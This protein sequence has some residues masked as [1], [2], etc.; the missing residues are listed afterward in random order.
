MNTN[1]NSSIAA[2]T[3]AIAADNVLHVEFGYDE[4]ECTACR[5]KG[6]RVCA[7][8]GTAEAQLIYWETRRQLADVHFA[9]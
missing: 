5:G 8:F 7:G 3:A 6:C 1:N 4:A 9:A 2:L